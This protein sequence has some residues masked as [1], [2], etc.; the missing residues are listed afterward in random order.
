MCKR[1]ERRWLAAYEYLHI[2]A[3]RLM[4]K[5]YRYTADRVGVQPVEP[6][7][8]GQ[9]LFSLLFPLLV[10]L[11]AA[12]ALGA[13]WLYTYLTLF[14]DIE[15]QAYYGSAPRWH[16]G[17]QILAVLL[18]IFAAPAYF[19]VRRAIRLLIIQPEEHVV[20]DQ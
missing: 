3:Y 11:L 8:R 5:H 19:D 4:N 14:P 16:I 18:P 20:G 10:V 1:I 17:L 13:L 6:L 7:T 9:H 15:P 2:A 12:L